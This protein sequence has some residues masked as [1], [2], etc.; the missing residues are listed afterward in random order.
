MMKALDLA[1]CRE[2]LHR[3]TR[4][5]TTPQRLVIRSRIL[6]LLGEGHSAREVARMLGVSRHTVNL[7]RQRFSAGGC[8]AIAHDKPGRGRR[9][10]TQGATL[11]PRL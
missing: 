6:L 5:P 2:R 10:M 3:W 4:S 7:W 1:D 11:I 8:D 9:T